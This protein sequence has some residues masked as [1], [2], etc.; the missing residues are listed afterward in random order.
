MHENWPF[1]PLDREANPGQSCVVKLE[2]GIWAFGIDY[3]QGESIQL[4]V[5]GS[6]QGVSNFHDATGSKNKGKHVLYLGGSHDSH[7]VL[8]FV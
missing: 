4:Q 3:E 7:V 2:I 1:T 6:L 8:P 5:C